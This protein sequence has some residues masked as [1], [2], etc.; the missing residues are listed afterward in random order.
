[1]PSTS[2]RQARAMQAAAS[3]NSMS[4]IPQNVGRE[5]T[6]AD[7]L[8]RGTRY[9]NYTEPGYGNYTESGYGNHTPKGGLHHTHWKPGRKY[10]GSTVGGGSVGGGAGASG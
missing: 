3:G 8:R 4:G 6:H 2:R 10:G 9:G 7:A 5:Y 1:M